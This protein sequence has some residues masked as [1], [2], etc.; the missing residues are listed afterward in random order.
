[1]V[2][3][4]PGIACTTNRESSKNE[5]RFHARFIG[6]SVLRLAKVF[7]EAPSS[8]RFLFSGVRGETVWKIAG[9]LSTTLLWQH[10][11][12]ERGPFDPSWRL[13][14]P[15]CGTHPVFPNSLGRGILGSCQNSHP[16]HIFT[17]YTPSN[18][19]PNKRRYTECM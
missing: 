16:I 11:V 4:P 8:F 1:M 19:Q 10:E 12:A 13:S 15:R 9:G 17:H 2:Y 18:S 6:P 3:P 14:E 7:S 5:E